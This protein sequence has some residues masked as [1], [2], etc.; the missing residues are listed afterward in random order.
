MKLKNFSFSWSL[1]SKGHFWNIICL[2]AKRCFVCLCSLSNVTIY[3]WS[4]CLW[5][6]WYWSNVLPQQNRSTFSHPSQQVFWSYF[7]NSD[8]WDFCYLLC[9]FPFYFSLFCQWCYHI[10]TFFMQIKCLATCPSKSKLVLS[11]NLHHNK[12]VIIFS[13][14][15]MEQCS[16]FYFA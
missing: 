11:Q 16:L 8:F 14:V 12:A 6:V 5:Y 1:S 9:P 3:C 10:A 2:C 4:V 13:E 15:N 7:C